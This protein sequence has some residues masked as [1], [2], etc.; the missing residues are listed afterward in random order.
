MTEAKHTHTH[1]H[2]HTQERN[3]QAKLQPSGDSPLSS[4]KE[5][6]L[7][8]NKRG[9]VQLGSHYLRTPHPRPYQELGKLRSGAEQLILIKRQRRD[10]RELAWA[11]HAQ[12]GQVLNL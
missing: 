12:T 1:T 10:M 3:N 7:A 6:M 4:S 8:K 11:L 5:M 2:T 9:T